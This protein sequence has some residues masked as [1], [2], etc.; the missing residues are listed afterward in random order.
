MLRSSMMELYL[1]SPMYVHSVVLN[2]IIKYRI[3]LTLIIIIICWRYTPWW[4][5]VSLLQFL[6]HIDNRWDTLG[7]R[8]ACRRTH[9]HKINANRYPCLDWHSS[10]RRRF[11]PV[12]ARTVWSANLPLPF[13]ITRIFTF[14]WSFLSL[15]LSLSCSQSLSSCNGGSTLLKEMGAAGFQRRREMRRGRRVQKE[16]GWFCVVDQKAVR[17]QSRQHFKWRKTKGLGRTS[18]GRW[19]HSKLHI[20]K[21]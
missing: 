21:K 8:S 15:T 13:K 11:I 20:K 10:G 7:E 5:L 3:N 17:F 1:S 2:Y 16:E 18:V 6:D 9:R 14:E 12:T 19:S 4:N